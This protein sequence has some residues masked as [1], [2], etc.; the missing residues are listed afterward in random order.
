MPKDL[1]ALLTSPEELREAG[2]EEARMHD[3]VIAERDAYKELAA[4]LDKLVIAYRTQPIGG[5][6]NIGKTIDRVKKAR[7][8][9]AK[10]EAD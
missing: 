3:A 8:L 9:L 1:W 10:I 4:A 2:R 7:A 6:R 5:A